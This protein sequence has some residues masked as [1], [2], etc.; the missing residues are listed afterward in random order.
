MTRKDLRFFMQGIIDINVSCFSALMNFTGMYAKGR[1]TDRGKEIY[2]RNLVEYAGYRQLLRAIGVVADKG[3]LVRSPLIVEII[4]KEMEFHPKDAG[5][6]EAR[7]DHLSLAEMKRAVQ[8]Y[9]DM[10][11]WSF[12]ELV[13]IGEVP[14][15]RDAELALALI[16]LINVDIQTFRT[17][18]VRRVVGKIGSDGKLIKAC[19]QN[20]S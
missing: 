8:K 11:E 19:I 5:C 7:I 4:K 14:E 3:T 12:N 2:K 17:G 10:T 9:L 1:F 6:Y 16:E 18:P 13:K 15:Q 20:Q